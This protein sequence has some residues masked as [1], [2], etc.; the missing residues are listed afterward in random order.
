LVLGCAT[1]PPK[2]LVDA[3]AAYARAAGGPATQLAPAD[4]HKA[5]DILGKA[6]QSFAVAPQAQKTRD[7]AYIAGRKA[8]IAE[9]IAFQERDNRAKAQANQD[10]TKTQGKALNQTRDQLA[11]SQETQRQGSERLDQERQARVE[12]EGK[13]ADGERKNKML[14]DSLAKL[15]AVKEEAR[16]TVI[17]LS[18]SV[19]FASNKSELLP[20][21][22]KRLT[23]VA[24]ALG[25]AEDRKV[26][27]EGHTDSRGSDSYNMDLSQRRA[28]AVRSYLVSQGLSA[29]L[30]RAE[31]MGKDRPIADNTSAEGRANNRRVEIVLAPRTAAR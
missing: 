14:A 29:D 15:A 31:G 19:L 18:G 23:Q 24:E 16:G 9:A 20:A 10:F 1:A 5:A 25:S 6:E 2:E 28:D 17:T 8:Q 30:T 4:L 27:V 12:A 3:R 26:V 22:R 13:V 7:L 21:A 11:Q